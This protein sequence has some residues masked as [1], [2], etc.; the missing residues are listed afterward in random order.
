MLERL[1]AR[2]VDDWVE[3]A[4]WWSVRMTALGGILGGV[5]AAMPA[6]PAEVQAAVPVKFRV[7]A[8]AV[9]SVASI[10]TRVV[11]QNPGAAR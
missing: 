4:R 10:I 3:F 11:K 7:A 8:I 1:K 6:M 2:L 9:W 5:L